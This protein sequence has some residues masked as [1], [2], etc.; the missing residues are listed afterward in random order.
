MSALM[1]CSA[2]TGPASLK[3]CK[4]RAS[5]RGLVVFP[6]IS[7]IS[8]PPR[9]MSVSGQVCQASLYLRLCLKFYAVSPEEGGTI[10]ELLSC[11]YALEGKAVTAIARRA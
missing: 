10:D 5:G 3:A 2:S 7:L 8:L 9:Q 4:A 6:P 11:C 1:Q